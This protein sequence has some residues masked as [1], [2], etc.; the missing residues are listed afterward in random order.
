MLPILKSGSS[1]IMAIKESKVWGDDSGRERL[2]RKQEAGF[3]AG[4]QD[5]ESL[6]EFGTLC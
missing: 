3:H 2:E 5:A 1:I 4:A 6:M